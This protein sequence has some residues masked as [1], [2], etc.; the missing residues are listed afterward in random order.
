ML[1]SSPFHPR[2][3]ETITV[4]RPGL[5]P[6]VE[7]PTAD[8]YSFTSALRHIHRVLGQEEAPEHLAVDVGLGPA[9]VLDAL[10][11]VCRH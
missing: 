9:E 3:P 7:R 11:A 5:E 1:L 8:A 4:L 10:R 6:I 2:P